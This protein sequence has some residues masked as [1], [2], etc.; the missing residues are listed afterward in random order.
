M[1]N[2]VKLA[3][4]ILFALSMTA[5]ADEKPMVQPSG[6]QSTASQPAV[7]KPAKKTGMKKGGKKSSKKGGKKTDKM[8]D[9]AGK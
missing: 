6:D 8:M 9:K 2:I 1:K 3:T 7:M 5:F 4:P